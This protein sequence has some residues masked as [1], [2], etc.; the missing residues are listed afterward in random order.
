MADG[1]SKSI[2]DI[3]VGDTLKA[4]DGNNTVLSLIRP[5]LG[6]QDIYSINGQKAFFTANHPFLTTDGWKSLDPATT[7][8][9]IPDLEVTLL[10]IGDV[11]ITEHS[12]ILV[13][14]ISSSPSSSS[15]QLYN[16]ELDGDHTYFANGF[17]VHNKLA[18]VD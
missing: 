12:K 8:K 2:Q 16:F 6:H 14:S 18:P 4:V 7:K 1:S 5:T 17:A 11:L 10:E 3:K 9:E 15:T 13:V